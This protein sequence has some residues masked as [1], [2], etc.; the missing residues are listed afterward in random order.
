MRLCG[1]CGNGSGYVQGCI[2]FVTL[3]MKQAFETIKKQGPFGSLVI[4]RM[5]FIFVFQFGNDTLY[6]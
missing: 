3:G 6:D 2:W 1:W 5:F 4:I